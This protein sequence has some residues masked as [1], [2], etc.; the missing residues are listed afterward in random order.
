MTLGVKALTTLAV[1]QESLDLASTEKVS[2]IERLIHAISDATVEFCGREF[3]YE[4]AI[5]ERHKGYGDHHLVV[6]RGPIVSLTSI[7]LKNIDGTTALTFD[8][9]SYEVESASAG[10][11][12]R[13]GATI[14]TSAPLGGGFPWTA[15]GGAGI[16]GGARAGT[17][18]AS[19]EVTY[20]GGYKTPNQIDN[21]GQAGDRSLPYD[22]EQA[23]VLSVIY[24]FRTGS[25]DTTIASKAT[26]EVTT[27]WLNP[28]KIV[29][30]EAAAL[31][32]QSRAIL[33]RYQR[34]WLD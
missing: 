28:S 34:A 15:Q 19:I 18:R 11:I 1:V 32:P 12:A 17:E 6:Y 9:D 5:V 2:L 29:G 27:T 23:V 3:H 13:P 25:R 16:R 24:A 14:L 4:D 20:D 21:L 10:I 30:T 7:T 31:T 33:T 22:L 26:E 8:T